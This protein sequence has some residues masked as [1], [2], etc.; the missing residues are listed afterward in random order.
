MGLLNRSLNYTHTRFRHSY[1]KERCLRDSAII[2]QVILYHDEFHSFPCGIIDKK[3]SA[4]NFF[5]LML[6]RYFFVLDDILV[7]LLRSVNE[8]D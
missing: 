5:F 2:T 7:H 3:F 1:V 4:V 6:T 8:D